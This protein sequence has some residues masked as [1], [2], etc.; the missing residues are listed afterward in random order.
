MKRK[1]RFGLVFKSYQVDEPTIQ[2]I[3]PGELDV[4]TQRHTLTFISDEPALKLAIF[5]MVGHVNEDGFLGELRS[6]CSAAVFLF[7][8]CT[9]FPRFASV[10]W[11]ASVRRLTFRTKASGCCGFTL[12]NTPRSAGTRFSRKRSREDFAV[13]RTGVSRNT[14]ADLLRAGLVHSNRGRTR[15]G[16]SVSRPFPFC[17]WLVRC[18]KCGE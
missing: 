18:R 17:K 9:R 2:E 5:F 8:G 13:V 3:A 12:T 11:C 7:P 4:S 1:A 14:D 16:R 15:S 10:R 6:S